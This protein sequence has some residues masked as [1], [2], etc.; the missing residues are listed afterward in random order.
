[1]SF[2]RAQIANLFVSRV[3]GASYPPPIAT[4]GINNGTIP[5]GTGSVPPLQNSNLTYAEI[6][7]AS[8]IDRIGGTIFMR[9]M[10][11]F[12]STIDGANTVSILNDSI[13]ITD[14]TNN[15]SI[16]MNGSGTTIRALNNF[17]VNISSNTGNSGDVMTA[18]GL[19]DCAWVAPSGGGSENNLNWII[20]FTNFQ[21]F[22]LYPDITSW[23]PAV[24]QNDPAFP[25]PPLQASWGS[26]DVFAPV[27]GVYQFTLVI[28]T[29]PTQGILHVD[30]NGVDTNIDAYSSGNTSKSYVWSQSLVQGNNTMSLDT[31][32]KNILSTDYGVA[33]LGTGIT[34]AFLHGP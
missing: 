33:F 19:G 13:A 1:M 12:L 26:T 4:G 8:F 28:L 23:F 18:N 7:S 24:A 22:T 21:Y 5:V 31:L 32:T 34:V 20:P 10:S 14:N 15:N 9:G 16:A 25:Q 29:G 17:S 2:L 3:N 11:A 6:G 27:V 30:I